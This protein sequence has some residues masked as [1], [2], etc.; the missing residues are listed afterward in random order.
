MIGKIDRYGYRSLCLSLDGKAK[1]ITL[2]RIVAICYLDNHDNLPQ[3]NHKD[4]DKQNNRV[5]NLEWCTAQHNTQHSYNI[6]TSKAWNKGKTG[7]YSQEQISTMKK[8]QPNKKGVVVSIDSGNEIP[9]GLVKTFDS[10]REMC[11]QMGFDRR[12]A[13][14]VLKGESNY[15]SINGFKI[16]YQ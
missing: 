2:H 6:G 11:K 4:G 12:T 10:I 16:S 9:Y 13:M 3:V 8:N 5:T 1:H 14:R 7:V 15:N